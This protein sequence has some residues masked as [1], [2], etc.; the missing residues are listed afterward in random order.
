P[1]TTLTEERVL[2]RRYRQVGQRFV[3]A[4]IERANNK[5]TTWAKCP[6]DSRI[7]LELLVLSR[8]IQSVH[9]KK[10]GAKQTNAF[11]AKLDHLLSV[12]WSTNICDYLDALTVKGGRWAMRRLKGGGAPGPCTLFA[13]TDSFTFAFVGRLGNGPFC[14]VEN[15]RCAVRKLQNTWIS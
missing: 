5:W 1:D 12:C 7:C 9:K 2:F 6:S 13:F 15:H 10:L 11:T 8:G 14:A 4:D 3:A